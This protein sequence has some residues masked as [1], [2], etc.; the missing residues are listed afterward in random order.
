MHVTEEEKLFGAHSEEDGQAAVAQALTA[1]TDDCVM[2]LK[3]TGEPSNE[4]M[5]ARV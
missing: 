2:E 1:F 4:G 5:N 3:Q